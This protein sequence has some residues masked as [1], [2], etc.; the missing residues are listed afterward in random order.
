MQQ[1]HHNF[2]YPVG[3]YFSQG[4]KISESITI[5]LSTLNITLPSTQLNASCI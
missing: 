2:R 1:K 5:L 3:D 4:V